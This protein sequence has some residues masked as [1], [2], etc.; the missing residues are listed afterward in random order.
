MAIC[1][2]FPD[3]QP[4]NKTLISHVWTKD[5]RFFSFSC[6]F[7]FIIQRKFI[8]IIGFSI[9]S[10]CFSLDTNFKLYGP[11]QVQGYKNSGI[12]FYR[13]ST[14]GITIAVIKANK[15]TYCLQKRIQKFPL[16]RI[17]KT[18]PSWCERNCHLTP[19]NTNV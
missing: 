10:K 4:V 2:S 17:L 13:K 11:L 8:R 16:L 7:L 18:A 6:F 5:L 12:C 3:T 14:T 9:D 15:D 19:L 1:I